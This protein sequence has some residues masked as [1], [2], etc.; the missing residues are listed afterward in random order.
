[1]T[2]AEQRERKRLA[3]V[4]H[5]HIQQL[6]VGSKIRVAMLGRDGNDMVKQAVREAE[7][8]IDECI[9]A[10]RSLTAELSLHIPHKAGLN[11]ELEWLASWMAD[12]QG[13]SVALEME[14]IGPLPYATKIL[15][16]ESVRELLFNAVKHSHTRSARVSLGTADG[17]LRLIV[18]DQG[19]GFD[20]N[21]R[22]PGGDRNAF[23]CAAGLHSGTSPSGEALRILKECIDPGLQAAAQGASSL[24]MI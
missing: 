17:F 5:D 6:L 15:L 22:P 11:A 19:V 8:M 12:K 20:T 10:S 2:L 1:L 24:F 9:A 13:F 3:K 23:F 14:A 16:F 18:S 4:L 21:A 7:G